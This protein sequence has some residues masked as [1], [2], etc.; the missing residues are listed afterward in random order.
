[1]SG[2]W[3]ENG[4]HPRIERRCKIKKRE[5]KMR[6]HSFY[7]R[8]SMVNQLRIKSETSLNVDDSTHT[9]THEKIWHKHQVT[10]THTPTLRPTIKILDGFQDWQ[11]MPP[12]EWTDRYPSPFGNT[13]RMPMLLLL[14]HRF[15]FSFV[16]AWALIGL[17][18]FSPSS[19]HGR[20]FF[21]SFCFIYPCT[22]ATPYT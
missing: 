3:C 7:I 16:F 13:Y 5:E 11:F 20:C 1:M 12:Q 19:W 6:S 9:H 10:H 15:H 2:R 4:R 18:L 22:L 21:L 8:I 17:V 14:Y